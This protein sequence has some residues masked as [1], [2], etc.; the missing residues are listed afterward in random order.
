MK[1]FTKLIDNAL[2]AMAKGVIVCF[3]TISVGG[4]IY[5]IMQYWPMF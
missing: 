4:I 5:Q 3:I 1:T 2:F